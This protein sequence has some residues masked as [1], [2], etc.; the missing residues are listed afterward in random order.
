[1]YFD[2][3]YDDAMYDRYLRTGDVDADWLEE[4]S[5]GLYYGPNSDDEDYDYA[6][7]EG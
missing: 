5:G 1:M 4:K 2:D 3:P 7:K 6:P